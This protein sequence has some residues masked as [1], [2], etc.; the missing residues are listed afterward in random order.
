LTLFPNRVILHLHQRIGIQPSRVSISS[1]LIADLE[2]TFTNLRLFNIRLNP[3]NCT[4][5]VPQ[6]KLLG[7]IITKRG[8]EVNPDK[9]SAIVE[10]DQVRDV[11]D[12][13][14]LTG[15]LAALSRFMSRLRECGLPC[16]SY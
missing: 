6:G 14:R 13:Q 3:K 10:I 15:C 1:S 11:K 8:I 7:Y 2:K 16:T 9:I 5:G 4:F 12:V